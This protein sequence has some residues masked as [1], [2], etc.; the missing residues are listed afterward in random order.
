MEWTE[1]S[2]WS[3]PWL[4][5]AKQDGQGGVDV[6]PAYHEHTDPEKAYRYVETGPGGL[7]ELNSE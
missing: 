1:W 3:G 7:A 4:T 6:S 5:P 2:G